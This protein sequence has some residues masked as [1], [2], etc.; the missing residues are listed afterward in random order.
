MPKKPHPDKKTRARIRAVRTAFRK[1]PASVG[2]LLQRRTALTGLASRTLAQHSWCAWL[3][4]RLPVELAAHVVNVVPKPLDAAA[5]AIELVVL[6]DSPV[7]SAR[8][9]YALAA[10]QSKIQN[11][12]AAVQHTRVRVSMHGGSRRV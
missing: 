11:H 2:D 1:A 7:W 9:R 10:L 4:E 12:D 3:R 5:S 8:L 6:A